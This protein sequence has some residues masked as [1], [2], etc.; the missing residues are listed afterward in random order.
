MRRF[1]GVVMLVCVLLSGAA[2][3]IVLALSP[4]V[5][6]DDV[7]AY[8]NFD[9]GLNDRRI[10]FLDLKRDA[11]MTLPNPPYQNSYGF[12]DAG[13]FAY[14]SDVDGNTEVFLWDS[15]TLTNISQHP[16]NDWQPAIS[17]DGRIAFTSERN[18][19]MEIYVWYNGTLTNISQNPASDDNPTWSADGRLAYTSTHDGNTGMIVWDGVYT[20]NIS[21]GTAIVNYRGAWSADRRL[22]FLIGK[23]SSELVVWEGGA[24]IPI[25]AA[26]P[27]YSWSADGR[28]AFS[29]GYV[30]WDTDIYIWDGQII[31]NITQN[32]AQDYSYW[33]TWASDGRL[34][35]VS[36][37]DGY[38]GL[39][40]WNGRTVRRVTRADENI[41]A[42]VWRP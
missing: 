39:Y 13:R 18:G 16:M 9:V 5:P 38:D 20:S 23:Q 8:T 25:Q 42:P 19:N 4:A 1:Y 31:S 11:R 35:F 36:T 30:A 34:A 41:I 24:L 40:V 28:L 3:L 10:V 2:L 17:P 22:A 15:G 12:D 26:T 33:P 7:I 6:L 27:G 21:S 32:P 29:S 14:L 37:R